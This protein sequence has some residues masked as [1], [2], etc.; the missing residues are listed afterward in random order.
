M[1]GNRKI[2][3]VGAGI[4]GL[5]CAWLLNEKHEITLFEA[6]NYI[7]GHTNTVKVPDNGRPVP[8]DTGFIVFNEQ[9]YPNLCRLFD[10]LGVPYQ[11]SDMSFSVHCEESGLVYNGTSIPSLFAQKRNLLNLPFLGM[12]KEILHFHGKAE[13]IIN[14]GIDDSVTVG[15]FVH[16]Q[17]YSDIF[18]KKFLV[19]LGASLWS[20]PADR[21]RE[22]PVKFVLEFLRNHSMLQVNGR[23]T[24]KTV[25]GGS[26]RY[27]GE[28]IRPYM[29][30]IRLNSP[31]KSIRRSG[32]QVA[33]VLENNSVEY[34]DDVI[35]A[36]HSDQALRMLANPDEDE[37]EILGAFRY[38]KNEV[39]LHTDTGL[40]PP[41]KHAWGSW[42]YRI[43]EDMTR[44][45]AVTYNMNLLQS[46]ETDQTY[47][48]SLN[49]TRDIDKNRIIASFNYSHP[50][51]SPGRDQFQSRHQDLIRHQG[52]SYCGAYWGYGF[53]EDGVRSALAVCSEFGRGEI[54]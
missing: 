17:G 16:K 5:T 1:N 47:C 7:G 23:P 26:S 24:W 20:S 29:D 42:N 28:M 45:A 10:R 36:A 3:I 41:V 18:F 46:L 38:E 51:F 12:L 54:R 49:Q 13:S 34:F 27:V 15:E 21:F 43:L 31:V 14:N 48:V 53:H 19:P 37:Q 8:V 35:I 25:T 52:I 44:P 40:L 32:K 50:Q 6:N 30:R 39:V 9:N 11:D 2:A 4:S 33:V 22:F